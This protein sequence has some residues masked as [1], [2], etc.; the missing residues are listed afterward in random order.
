MNA[1]CLGLF[2]VVAFLIRL[3]F[4]AIKLPILN[5]T[6]LDVSICLFC[7]PLFSS[8]VGSNAGTFHQFLRSTP[9]AFTC[10]CVLFSR[11]LLLS[12]PSCL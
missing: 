1:A 4:Y 9:S 7:L 5:E 2:V 11:L 8:V 3:S 10:E 6:A 12:L